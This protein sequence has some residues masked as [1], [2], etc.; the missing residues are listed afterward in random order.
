MFF[1]FAIGVRHE[2]SPLV[3]LLLGEGQQRAMLLPRPRRKLIGGMSE[4]RIESV[5]D[6]LT[7]PELL[8]NKTLKEVQD[9]LG[10]PP[11]NWR[12]ERLRRGRSAG[13]GWVLREYTRNGN[14]TGRMIRYHPG[15]GRHGPEPYWRVMNSGVKSSIISAAT[16]SDRG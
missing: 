6:L 1:G 11:A 10:A 16:E 5:E 15:G 14:E 8:R 2:S 13:K 3:R 7:D 4:R 9:L 12:V